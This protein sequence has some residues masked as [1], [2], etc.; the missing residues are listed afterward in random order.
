VQHAP[1]FHKVASAIRSSS[2]PCKAL[3]IPADMGSEWLRDE[4]LPPQYLGMNVA[5]CNNIGTH[6]VRCKSFVANGSGQ[7]IVIQRDI[8]P[9]SGEWT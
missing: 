3:C 4:V 9:I 7:K 2:A 6:Q 5:L 8:E 1:F